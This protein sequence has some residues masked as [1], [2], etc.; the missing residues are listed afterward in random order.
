MS[1]KHNDLYRL[2]KDVRDSHKRNIMKLRAYGLDLLREALKAAVVASKE[3]QTE[4]PKKV[5]RETY[6]AVIASAPVNIRDM[7][8]VLRNHKG[9]Q[10]TKSEA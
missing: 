2:S 8:N 1:G 6:E 7:A 9:P 5:W 4:D 3:T 10:T